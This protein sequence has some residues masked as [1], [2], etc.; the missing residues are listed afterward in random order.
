VKPYLKNKTKT[1][2]LG[3]SMVVEHLPS[4]YEALGSILRTQQQQQQKDQKGF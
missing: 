3:H 4:K 1:K 2:G